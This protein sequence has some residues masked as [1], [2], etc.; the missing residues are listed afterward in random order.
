MDMVSS[1]VFISSPS[2]RTCSDNLDLPSAS[3]I[4]EVKYLNNKMTVSV[5]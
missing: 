1:T 4:C 3:L 5:M 2:L